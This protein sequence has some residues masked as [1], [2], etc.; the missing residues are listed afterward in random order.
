M[1]LVHPAD[2]LR[3][4]ALR[5]SFLERQKGR[6]KDR[7]D[8]IAIDHALAM[9]ACGLSF[10]EVCAELGWTISGFENW[11]KDHDDIKDL[12]ETME[13]ALKAHLDRLLNESIRDDTINVTSLQLRIKHHSRLFDTDLIRIDEFAKLPLQGKVAKIIDLQANGDITIR[14]T[15]RL[16]DV[17]TRLEEVAGMQHIATKIE[18]MQEA[19]RLT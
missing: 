2:R 6:I 8:P 11:C 16:L 3:F 12:K 13:L 18:E 4:V 14:D 9:S 19:M 15:N 7:P 10:H 1:E 5:T 17:L